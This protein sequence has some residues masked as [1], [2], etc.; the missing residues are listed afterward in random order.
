MVMEKIVENKK[1]IAIVIGLLVVCCL[2]L[3]VAIGIGYVLVDDESEPTTTPPITTATPQTTRPITKP[4]TRPPTTSSPQTTASPDEE[5]V[6]NGQVGNGPAETQAPTNKCYVKANPHSCSKETTLIGQGLKPNVATGNWELDT[7]GMEEYGAGESKENC[8]KRAQ[9][10][11][12]HCGLENVWHAA[13]APNK[14][15]ISSAPKSHSHNMQETAGCY[16]HTSS[17]RDINGQDRGTN[18]A[19]FNYDQHSDGTKDNCLN[20]RGQEFYDFCMKPN[21]GVTMAYRS[22]DGAVPEF[23]HYPLDTNKDGECYYRTTTAIPGDPNTHGAW[24]KDNSIT[25][26][27]K[28]LDSASATRKEVEWRYKDGETNINPQTQGARIVRGNESGPVGTGVCQYTAPTCPDENSRTAEGEFRFDNYGHSLLN[29]Q[30]GDY[31][32]QRDFFSYCG[33]D[34]TKVKYISANG[35]STVWNGIGSVANE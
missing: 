3:S 33:S 28:C 32:G 17:C 14:E 12:S 27:R 35:T 11:A 26:I 8:L 13:Y 9:A 24:A 25:K 34:N 30:Y 29:P 22:A 1:I 31:C 15:S 4:V 5:P 21:R 20:V 23:K 10:Y 7:W 16:Y 19:G 18:L 2:C 6:D